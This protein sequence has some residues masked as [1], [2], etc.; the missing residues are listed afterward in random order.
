M[1]FVITGNP[2]VG[3][4]TIT[5]EISDQLNLP[6]LDINEIAKNAGLF[7]SDGD[8]FDVDVDKLQT[9]MMQKTSDSC[10]IVGHLA[11]YVLEPE[12]IDKVIVLRR[13]PYDLFNIYEQRGYSQEK[14]QENAGSEVLGV[15]AFDS[16]EKFGDKVFQ[17]NIT[18]K[19]IQEISKRVLNI[20]NNRKDT[21]DNVDW[22]E[23]MTNKEDLKKFFAY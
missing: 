8:T 18:G 19:T 14:A 5:N 17:I 13:N 10:L 23:I 7:E 11:P 16:M 9:V 3:K 12:K 4:H 6:I 15:I 22:L 21:S 1:I 20:L 2:G